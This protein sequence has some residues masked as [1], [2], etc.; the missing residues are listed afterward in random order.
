MPSPKDVKKLE[1]LKLKGINVNYPS[2]PWFTDNQ[3][4]I[5]KDKLDKESRIANA[6]YSDLLP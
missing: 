4:Q 6:Q 1:S 3:E 2:A 5:Q